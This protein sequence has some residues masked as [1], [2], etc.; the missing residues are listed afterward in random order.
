MTLRRPRRSLVINSQ[1][2]SSTRIPGRTVLSTS[3]ARL[4]T[5]KTG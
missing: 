4:A 1:A 3:Q 2:A 5:V